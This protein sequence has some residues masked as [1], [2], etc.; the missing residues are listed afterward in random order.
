MAISRHREFSSQRNFKIACCPQKIPPVQAAVTWGQQTRTR[1]AIVIPQGGFSPQTQTRACG[2]KNPR[3][4]NC[5]LK[6]APVREPFS[7]WRLGLARFMETGGSAGFPTGTP[8]ETR[9]ISPDAPGL[10]NKQ[11]NTALA[12]DRGARDDKTSAKMLQK[13]PWGG[14]RVGKR[15]RMRNTDEC[16][17][18]MY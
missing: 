16:E 1:C 14:L 13:M 4:K 10:P 11:T 2:P 8:P 12:V 18:L 3:D 9:P 5:G 15:M 6:N 7:N 17:S